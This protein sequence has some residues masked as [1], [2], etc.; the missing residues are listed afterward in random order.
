MNQSRNSATMRLESSRADKTRTNVFLRADKCT[1]LNLFIKLYLL[2][3]VIYI[4]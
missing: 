3:T 1:Q 4:F 2:A